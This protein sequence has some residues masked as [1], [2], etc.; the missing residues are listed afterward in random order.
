VIDGWAG[1]FDYSSQGDPSDGRGGFF[2]GNPV[3]TATGTYSALLNRDW[4]NWSD[5][6]TFSFNSQNGLGEVVNAGSIEN[7]RFILLIPKIQGSADIQVYPAE[8]PNLAGSSSVP[9]GFAITVARQDPFS[10]VAGPSDYYSLIEAATGIPW[11]E[12]ESVQVGGGVFAALSDELSFLAK[13]TE[14]SIPYSRSFGNTYT[15]NPFDDQESWV[16]PHSITP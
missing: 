10:T 14:E 15:G 16:Y 3:V 7:K 9:V 13:L 12:V 5:K 6:D 11:S 4:E 2:L 1:Q 8:W